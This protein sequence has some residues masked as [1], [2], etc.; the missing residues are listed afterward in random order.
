M[1][2]KLKINFLR[3]QPDILG[4]Y[5]NV[6]P[7][8]TGQDDRIQLDYANIDSIC[9]DAEA[10]EILARDVLDFVDPLKSETI[11]N[12]WIKKLRKGGQIVIGGVDL[13][14]V[15]HQVINA[16]L[17]IAQAN[18]ILRGDWSQPFN[19]RRSNVT[20]ETM[21]D[22]LQSKGLKILHRRI[23]NHHYSITAERE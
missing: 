3:N 14:E 8:A 12:H 7:L 17:N 6:D 9:E 19:I 23:S 11:I 4:G 2:S 18:Q 21:A 16:S 5:A 1:V 15:A 20:L 13:E 10:T 22:F